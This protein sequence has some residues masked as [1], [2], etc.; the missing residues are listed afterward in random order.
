M[1]QLL[2]GENSYEI[3]ARRNRVMAE[4][5]EAHGETAVKAVDGTTVTKDDL[6]QLL[7]GID[8]FSPEQLVVI[9]D[10]NAQKEVWE[11]LE[12][13]LVNA[14]DVLLIAPTA[15][16]RTR[17]YKWLQKN[18]EV[19]DLKPFQG[20]PLEQWLRTQARDKGI[21]MEAN[22]A[23]YMIEY[24]AGDQWSLVHDVEKLALSG[25]T[26]TAELIRELLIPNPTSSAFDLLDAALNKKSDQVAKLL[27][28][29]RAQEDPYRFFGLLSNQ[30]FAVLIV[31][32]A[33]NRQHDTIAKESALHPFVVKKTQ[34]LARKLS[35]HDRKRLAEVAAITDMQLKSSGQDP[36]V[37]IT[38]A[39]KTISA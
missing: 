19:S 30:I 8:L 38:A 20:L 36:W 28:G 12:T 1:I 14:S 2:T 21:D 4:F 15:D 35:A 34:P 18:A 29:V 6:P 16:K 9:D 26:V 39:L 33:G 17:T 25:K 37:L 7:Q 32:A 23:R 13:Y 22:V 31:A 27:D 5:R 11:A 10:V 3:R 24:T